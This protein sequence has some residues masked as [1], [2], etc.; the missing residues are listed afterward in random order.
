MIEKRTLADSV[1]H[2]CCES[3]VNVMLFLMNGVPLRGRILK[4]D[5]SAVAMRCEGKTQV[6]FRNMVST[7]VPENIIPCLQ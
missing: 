7:V 2:E 6:V 1:L 3:N 5:D 4:Y